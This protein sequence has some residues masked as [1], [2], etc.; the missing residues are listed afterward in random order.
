MKLTRYMKADRNYTTNINS[1]IYCIRNKANDKRYIGMSIDIEKRQGAHLRTLLEGTHYNKYLQCAFNKYG[2][3]AFEFTKVEP[4]DKEHMSNREQ[5][6]IKYFDTANPKRGYNLTIGGDGFTGKLS[7]ESLQKMVNT[8]RKNGWWKDPTEAKKN[9][10]KAMAEV[11]NRPEEKD[12]RKKPCSENRRQ[13]LKNNLNLQ[14]S[15][16]PQSVEHRKNNSIS[17]KGLHRSEASEQKR[18]ETRKRNGW[19]KNIQETKKK[20]RHP[21][22]RCLQI[23]GVG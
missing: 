7:K 6:W 12:K 4:A 23:I 10:S 14:K 8:R 5:Y 13:K 11:Q 17:H 16:G 2:Q 15:K 3:S 18:I 19:F 1:G 21:K 9:M 22:N 20:M